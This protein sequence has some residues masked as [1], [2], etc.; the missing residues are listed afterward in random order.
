MSEKFDCGLEG[1]DEEAVTVGRFN[2]WM[3][4]AMRHHLLPLKQTAVDTKKV[5]D[6]HIH[7]EAVTHAKI[8]GGITVLKWMVPIVNAVLLLVVWLLHKAGQI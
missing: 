4:I 1:A 8:E 2:R 7:E 3:S 5:L 6:D